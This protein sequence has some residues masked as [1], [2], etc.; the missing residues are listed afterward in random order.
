MFCPVIGR[1]KEEAKAKY[2]DYI[3]YGSAEG[4]LALF[5]GWTGIDLEPYGDDEELLHVE[6]NAIRAAVEVWAKFMPGVSKWTKHTV[7]RH[8]MTFS[9]SRWYPSSSS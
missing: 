9:Y 6:S 2:E 4:A 3:Q 8:L 7:A 1:T 5:G